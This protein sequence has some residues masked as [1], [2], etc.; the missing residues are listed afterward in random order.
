MTSYSVFYMKP[1]WFPQGVLGKQPYVPELYA[2]HA[3]VTDI[4]AESLQDVWQRMQ[5]ENWP[6][7]EYTTTTCST[8]WRAGASSI[9]Q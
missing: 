6:M 3:Y 7:G 4:T 1:E 5:A 2:T 9:P 8:S